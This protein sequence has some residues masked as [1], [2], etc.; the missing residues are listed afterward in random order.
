MNQKYVVVPAL[1]IQDIIGT[2]ERAR[3]IAREGTEKDGRDYTVLQVV[4]EWYTK[5]VATTR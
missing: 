3:Q 2:L 5:K 1:H 4:E